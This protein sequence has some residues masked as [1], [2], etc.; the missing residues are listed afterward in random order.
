MTIRLCT[1]TPLPTFQ[2]LK[3]SLAASIADGIPELTIPS[4][5]GLLSPIYEGFS[6]IDLELSQLV[7]E[8][9]AFQINLTMFN[10]FKPLSEFLGGALEDILPKIPGTDLTLL[11][12]INGDSAKVYQAV[13]QA[14]A[15]GIELPMIPSPIFGDIS[16]PGLETVATVKALLRGYPPLL[17]AKIK[18][19][20]A[21]VT[22]Q[23]EIP[24]LPEI[25]E[26]PTRETI[27]AALL[28]LFPEAERLAD[29]LNDD[30][31]V[32]ALFSGLIL[33]GIPP[34]ILP[35]PLVNGFSSFSVDFEEAMAIY[36]TNAAS[37]LIGPIVDFCNDALSSLGF[38][39]PTICIEF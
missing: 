37:A 32:S 39:F 24:G 15:D 31:S 3:E 23:L 27:E 10:I 17:V 14:I 30:F 26:L 35:E 36:M 22:D 38:E 25:P 12:I 7:Q 33:P 28:E 1:D 18:E 16:I 13:K 5:P 20:I 21:Q 29:M 11:D 9:Q 6:Q 19:L 2:A 4:L 8:L 34:L